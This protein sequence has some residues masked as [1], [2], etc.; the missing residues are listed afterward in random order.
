MVTVGSRRFSLGA[1]GTAV[2]KVPLNSAGRKFLAKFGKLPVTLT[3]KLTG[4][5][6]K[7]L[8]VHSAKLTVKPAKHHRH[9]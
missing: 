3:V 7:P 6:G 2:V 1:G 8:T 9:S 5:D 4:A